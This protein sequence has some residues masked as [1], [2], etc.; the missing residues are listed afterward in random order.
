M[1]TTAA[2]PVPLT[3]PP[4]AVWEPAADVTVRGTV[5]LLPGR[6]EH[7]GVYAR[8]GR[9]LAFDGYRVVVPAVPAAGSAPLDRVDLAGPVTE[10]RGSAPP[11]TPVVLAGSDT[12]ALLA[13][14]AARRAAPDGLL[15]VGLPTTVPPPGAPDT[16]D[17]WTDELGAR[18]SCPAHRGLLAADPDFRPGA[19]AE[20]VPADLAR[21]AEE[22]ASDD[23]PVSDI[24]VSGVPVLVVH[25]SADPVSPPATA[26]RFAGRLAADLVL[27]ADGRHDALNDAAHRSVAAAVVQWLE[28]LRGGP[29]LPARI[30]TTDAGGR[31]PDPRALE[32]NPA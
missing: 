30:V 27:V 4:S 12:G 28:R 18:T 16:A 1:T 24:P 9:R 22:A 31:T 32:G 19:L 26:R 11:G 20:D 6:G 10:A 3:G 7:P 15:L 29:H 17:N 23:V 13:L 8:F 25:G 14:A 21:A 5:L 2:S